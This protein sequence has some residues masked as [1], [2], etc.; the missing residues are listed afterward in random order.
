MQLADE[1]SETACAFLS[2]AVSWFA[3][4]NVRVERVIA[5]NSSAFVSKPF[6][7]RC[8]D[9]RLRDKRTRPYTTQTTA[10]RNASSTL[11]GDWRYRFAYQSSAERDRWLTAYLHVYNYRRTYSALDYNPPISRVDRR[12]VLTGNRFPVGNNDR[13][14]G[15][16]VGPSRCTISSHG[17]CSR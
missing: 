10:R 12:N 11:L 8:H 7:E 2:N 16:I 9:L 4:Q 3:N 13:G 6:R 5:D 14:E 15:S 1:R 17:I